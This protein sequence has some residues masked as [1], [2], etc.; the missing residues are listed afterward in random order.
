M[1]E[2]YDD[3]FEGGPANNNDDDGGGG[4]GG[5]GGVVN[6]GPEVDS[7]T[8]P[9]RP[10]GAKPTRFVA[11]PHTPHR[12]IGS[13]KAAGDLSVEARDAGDADQTNNSPPINTAADERAAEQTPA[14]QSFCYDFHNPN[15]GC[16]SLTCP[17]SHC[18]PAKLADGSVCMREN[19]TFRSHPH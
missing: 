15:K 4:G 1:D 13:S 10:S 8:V 5:G 9:Q 17:R 12:V 14:G 16:R 2:D 6:V 7:P 11:T 19:A 3:D 18:C